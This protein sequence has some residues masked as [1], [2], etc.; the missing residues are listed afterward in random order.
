MAIVSRSFEI[1]KNGRYAYVWRV[2]GIPVLS[3]EG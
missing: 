1:G 2:L 3:L